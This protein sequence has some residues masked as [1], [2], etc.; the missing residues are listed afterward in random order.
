MK[1]VSPGPERLRTA[2]PLFNRSIV[3]VTVNGY[4]AWM[5]RRA[6]LWHLRGRDRA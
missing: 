4:R 1:A 6:G 3:I 5:L 2:Y